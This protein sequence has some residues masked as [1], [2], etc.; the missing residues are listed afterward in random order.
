MCVQDIEEFLQRS[1]QPGAGVYIGRRAEF[2][3]NGWQGN[4]FGVQDALLDGE[5][6]HW[7]LAFGSVLVPAFGSMVLTS[8]ALA[9]RLGWR[10]WRRR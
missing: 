10:A 6:A 4:G 7:A 2:L 5:M 8:F 3:G 9:S 1:F